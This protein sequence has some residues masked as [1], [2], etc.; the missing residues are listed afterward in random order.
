MYRLMVLFQLH[1]QKLFRQLSLT[2]TI[3]D[4][5]VTKL[6]ISFDFSV[7]TPTVSLEPEKK[8]I[9]VLSKSM[10]VTLSQTKSRFTASE[11]VSLSFTKVH[12][13]GD[14]DD[15]CW[16]DSVTEVASYVFTNGIFPIF[17]ASDT[18]YDVHI[19][20]IVANPP[21]AA[22]TKN[23]LILAIAAVLAALTL[24]VAVGVIYMLRKS[25]LEIDTGDDEDESQSEVEDDENDGVTA[26]IDV[27]N[28]EIDETM[29]EV[30]NWL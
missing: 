5:V 2:L 23:S 4:T 28:E 11:T 22:A 18:L 10:G 29:N 12:C 24:A 25:K 20:S 9:D 1:K 7:P 6:Y 19:Q 30:D 26:T 14:S 15:D 17:V 8:F 27:P 3:A 21:S 13:E 16:V